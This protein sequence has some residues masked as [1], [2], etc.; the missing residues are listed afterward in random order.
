[1]EPWHYI[2]LLGAVLLV[3]AL[4]RP[5][6]R[7]QP[8]PAANTMQAIEDTMEQFSAELEE[9]NRQLLQLVSA[10]KHDHEKHSAKL[11]GR[12]EALERNNG[13]VS[14]Q[15]DRLLQAEETRKSQPAVT[16]AYVQSAVPQAE[17]YSTAPA[18]GATLSA[19][20]ARLSDKPIPI[21]S[22]GHAAAASAPTPEPRGINIRNRYAELF[23]LEKQ[24]KSVDYIAKK[25]GMNKGEVMLIL[26]LAKQED[27]VRA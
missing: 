27:R 22:V 1:M 2:V 20:V 7:Q 19:S 4:I 8:K 3:F 6:T 26:Q 14:K 21:E 23:Q 13:E 12:I 10:M 16:Q 17:G 11:Q 9:E 24:G 25:L 15:L 5:S 18:A